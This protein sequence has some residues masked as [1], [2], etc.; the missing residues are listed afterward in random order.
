M[1]AGQKFAMLELKSTVSNVLKHYHL[2]PAPP[3]HQPILIAEAILKSS[4]GI[5]ICLTK[6]DF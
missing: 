6:R 3:N 2:S 1:I 5:R 4:N